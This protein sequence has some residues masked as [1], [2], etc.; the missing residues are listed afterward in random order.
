MASYTLSPIGGAGSQFFDN[1]GNVLSGGKLYTYQ[2]GTTTPTP[3]YTNPAGTTANSNPVVFNSAGRPANEIWL[4]A[5][6]VYKF[7]LKDAN[8]VLI[9][10]YDNIP[11]LPQPPI[12]NDASSVS[13]EPNIIVSAGSFVVGQTYMI[14][15]LGSTDFVSIGAAYN[16]TGVIFT[17]TGA[18]SGTGTAYVSTT[19]QTRLRA[20]EASGGSNYI[21]FL[22]AGTGAVTRTAQS[23]LRETVSVK[24]FGAVGDGVTD[25][26][27]AIQ[28]ALN[29][30]NTWN[31]ADQ[32][33]FLMGS[34][35]TYLVSSTLIISCDCDLSSMKIVA[36]ASSVS[37]VVR[38]G[39][40]VAGEITW[41]KNITLPQVEN[42]SRTAG[43]WG[44]GVG[45][46]LTNCNTCIITVPQIR[47]FETGLSC[48][49]LSQGFA[50]N[51]VFLQYIVE[52]KINVD[53]STNNVGGW[54]NQNVFIGGRLSHTPSLFSG[55]TNVG[56]RDIVLG[57]ANGEANNNLFLNT[58]VEGS[59]FPE[60][61]IEFRQKTSYNILQNLR[62][63]GVAGKRVLFNTDFA[64]GN[65]SNLIFGGYQDQSITYTFTGTGS[66]VYN[67]QLYGRSSDINSTGVGFNITTGGGSQPHIQGFNA[68]TTS[69]GKNNTATDWTYRI[70]DVS[71]Q[72][73]TAGVLYPIMQM[74]NSGYLR[75]G[76]GSATPQ[77]YIRSWGVN[78][79]RFSVNS[80]STGSI[81]P[82]VDDVVSL[83][84]GGN[85]MSVIYAATGTINTSDEKEKQD[86]TD[87]NEAEKRVAV[88][89]KGLVKK[90]RFKDAVKKKGDD[91]RIHVGVIAQEVMAAFE[92]EGLDAMRYGLLCYDEWDAEEAELDE[93]GNVIHQAREAGNRYGV[94][95]D[96]LLAFM[97][98]AL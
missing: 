27:A 18:G 48:G 24:D 80:G 13:Y 5:E 28:A 36:N 73:K 16:S 49:G 46:Q 31:L 20:Y 93:E 7:V 61:S 22:Q 90:F 89:L 94:R 91:A 6:Y 88:K 42:N 98:T 86:I 68:G 62:Y 81:H 17:A 83:G 34:P 76:D 11:G 51:T 4:S 23:K 55:V 54:A 97:V 58:S 35:G 38:V 75:F 84:L 85:R 65:N 69:L 77:S 44:V 45:V 74:D 14:A 59:T 78:A 33:P 95:Y 57:N 37:P 19:V 25:D 43:Q 87:L 9:A 12:V 56:S 82:A 72:V 66:N 21:G 8:D 47:F 29:Y 79:L 52:N 96:E 2:A 10:T 70:N 63:E 92:A 67:S 40:T 64:A 26:T 41:R 39:G 15:S 3:T 32:K 71:Y 50:Y 1:S 53:V 30:C 60:Y